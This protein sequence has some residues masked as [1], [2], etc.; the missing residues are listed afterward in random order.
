MDQF[1]K[2]LL[3]INNALT[4][5]ELQTR[6]RWVKPGLWEQP[7]L[8]LCLEYLWQVYQYLSQ[9]YKYESA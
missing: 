2:V 6:I 9:M 1:S 8:S 3:P 5:T 4:V 7:S